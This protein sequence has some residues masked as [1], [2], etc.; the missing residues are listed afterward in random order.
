MSCPPLA[1][2]GSRAR[3]LRVGVYAGHGLVG[4]GFVGDVTERVSERGQRKP[5]V[6][7]GARRVLEGH[8]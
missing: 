8:G 1:P 4:D 5:A 7:A 6:R 2:D 3:R